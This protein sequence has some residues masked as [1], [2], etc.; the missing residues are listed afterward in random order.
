MLD[1]P[2]HPLI[3]TVQMY[4]QTLIA[5]SYKHYKCSQCYQVRIPKERET[6][7]RRS[8]VETYSRAPLTLLVAPTDQS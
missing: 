7:G 2:Q 1:P 5:K 4:K 3:R 6:Q 8:Q